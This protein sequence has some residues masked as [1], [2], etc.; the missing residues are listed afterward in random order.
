[1]SVSSTGGKYVFQDDQETPN[2]QIA[3]FDYGD[4]EL[5]FEVRGLP[6]GSEGNLPIRGKNSISNLFYGAD[7][8]MAMDDEGFQVYKGYEN[9]KTMDEK[10]QDKLA[11]KDET[12]VHMENFL[13]G[14]KSRNVADLHADVRIGATSADLVH[15]ANIS[16]RLKHE[17]KFDA[18]ALKFTDSSAANEMLTRKY[19]TPYV[20]PKEV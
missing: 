12:Q 2:T 4:K 15:L 5:M 1:M 17:L 14:V 18:K 16:Y 3:T 13:A 10:N 19:R 11:K 20:V 9:T 8:W 7:G 6:T